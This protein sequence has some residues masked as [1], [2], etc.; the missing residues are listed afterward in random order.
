V[1][2]FETALITGGST[3]I[4]RAIAHR[5]AKSGTK[6]AICARRPEQLEEA[7]AA[8]PD[9]IITIVADCADPARA[10]GVVGEAKE[11]L[12]SLDLVIANAG[13]GINKPAPKLDPKD[14]VDVFQLN[15]VGA[16]A[17]LTAAIPHML[18]ANKGHLVGI[19]SV[20]GNRGLPTSAAYSASKAA[21]SIFL[22]SLRVDLRGRNIG[23]TDIRPGFIDTP[24]TKKNKFPMPFLLP[25]DEAARRIVRAIER[26]KRIYTFPWPMAVAIRIVRMLPS[27]LYEWLASKSPV[28]A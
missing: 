20:A 6:V 5:L 26:N 16:C 25:A 2:R 3:G 22:E 4:G 17:T 18:A 19:S 9:H 28:S 21:V 11:K 27:W 12:G 24:L 8:Y 7:K 15:V 1:R 23:V 13:F 14:V 10:A